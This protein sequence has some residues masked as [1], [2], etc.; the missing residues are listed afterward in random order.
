MK[1]KLIPKR[2]LNVALAG[3][4][5]TMLVMP[6]AAGAQLVQKGRLGG[7]A[8]STVAI[9]NARLL[10][11]SSFSAPAD[12]GYEANPATPQHNV[13]L[14]TFP[15]FGTVLAAAVVVLPFGLSTLRILRRNRVT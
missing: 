6:F 3:M 12:G 13:F 8:D 15:G 2:I 11:D 5:G 4:L 14:A 7:V 10:E 9:G 1:S